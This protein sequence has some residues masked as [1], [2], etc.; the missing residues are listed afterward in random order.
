MTSNIS[1]APFAWVCALVLVASGCSRDLG[2]LEPAPNPTGGIVFE[3]EFTG[4]VDFQAFSTSK[5]DALN[6][7]RVDRYRGLTSLRFTVPGPGDPSGGYAGGAFVTSI[8]RDLTGYNALT[9]WAKASTSATFNTVGFGND[10]TGTSRYVAEVGD[11][12]LSTTWTKYVVPMPLASKLTSE[13]GLFFLADAPEHDVGYDLWLDDIQ[14]ETL[15]TIINPR[16]SIASQT[17]NGEAGGTL[18]VGGTQV[19]FDV[20]GSDV[21]VRAMPGYF[22]FQSSDESVA[23]VND[24]GAIVLVGSGTAR[25]TASLG[26]TPASGEVTVN[27]ATPPD[28]GPPEPAFP[29]ADV[30]SLFSDAY[31]DVPIDT[32]SAVWDQAD[33]EDVVIDGNTVKQYSNMV[34]AGVEFTSRPIDASAM[35][36]MHLDLWTSDPSVFRIKL[37]D[38]GADGAFG[39]GDDSEHEITLNEGSTP[40][41]GIGAWN[42]LDIPLSDFAGLNARGHLAQLIISGASPTVYLDNILFYST[43]PTTPTMP[44]APAEPAPTPTAAA[45]DVVSLFSGAYEDVPVDTWSAEWDQ[46][47]VEDVEVGGNLTK[48]YSNLVFAG[49]EFT[50]QTVD[51]SATSHFHMDIW[52]PDSTMDPAA[53]RVKLVDF[54]ADGAF[55]GG[56]DVEHELTFTE[57]SSPALATARWVGLDVPFSEFEGLTTRGHLAQMIL[58]GDPNTIYV[59]NVYFYSPAAAAPTE[60]AEPAPTPSLAAENVVSLYSNAYS[61]V[62]VDT[63]SAEWDQADLEDIQIGGDDVKKYSNLSFAGV[64]FTSATVDGSGMTHF[65]MDVWT[66]DSTMDPAAFRVKLVDFGADGAFQGGDDVEHELTFTQASDPALATG[67]WVALEVPLSAFEALTTRGHLAQMI[68]SGDPNTVFVDNVYLHN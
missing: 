17:V 46:A 23:A 1:P 59:D 54:G 26:G 5:V 19:T 11:I 57:A 62:T 37:V 12:P 48:R 16:P 28:A 29:A 10:N 38:F 64:E 27:V 63:W 49:I 35:S 4:G 67:N 25:I 9:F 43:E 51:A 6:V 2:P 34:F 30:I 8:G 53:F 31:D 47:D 20:A 45:S 60:P 52:T 22:T 42:V 39:G 13:R 61:D 15:G 68:I 24:E 21:T 14:F 58:S 44:I 32:W 41:I 7:D 65:H 50:S 33:V 40:P 56:D 55:Q 36:H 66:P 3:D 18:N